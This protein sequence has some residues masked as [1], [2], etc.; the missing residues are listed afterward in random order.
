MNHLMLDIETLD[1]KSTSS[2]LSLSAVQFD[3][4]NGNL[5]KQF[6]EKVSLSS[7]IKYGLTISES[8]LKW[9]LEQPI[10]VFKE[11]LSGEKDLREVLHE[12][13]LFI[14]SIGTN[15]LKI[16]GNSNRFD[17]GIL[18]NAYE[19]TGCKEI[20]WKYALERDVR[21]LV[22]FQP[23]IKKNEIFIGDPHNPLDDCKHQIKYCV[24]IYNQLNNK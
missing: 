8:T 5:G 15:D 19:K 21:T 16:W 7:N 22:S 3:L 20:P 9:W 11:A 18:Q 12:F 1:N 6:Y 13:R 10:E 23:G 4:E 2:I 17:C 14:Q 24:K